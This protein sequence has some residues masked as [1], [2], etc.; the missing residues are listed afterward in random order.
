MFRAPGALAA[1]VSVALAGCVNVHAPALPS[2][3]VPAPPPGASA[4]PAAVARPVPPKLTLPVGFARAV[5]RGTRTTDGRPGAGYWTNRATY[6]LTASLDP[7][8]KRLNGTARIHY[9]HNGPVALRELHL[10][11]TQNVHKSG[12]MRGEAMEDTD[13]VEL[14]RVAVGGRTL[15]EGSGYAVDGTDLTI[16][17]AQPLATGQSVNLDLVWAFTIPQSGAGARM[18]YVPARGDLTSADAAMVFLAYWYPQ[19]AVYDDVRGWNTDPFRG[20]GEF[21]AGYGDYTMTLD[22]PAGWA[23]Q[24]TGTLANPAEVYTSETNARLARAAASDTPV[25]IAT[26]RETPTVAVP[27]GGRLRYRY[28]ASNVRDVAFFATRG[29]AW[30]AARTVVGDQ[31]GDGAPD[32]ALAQALYRTSAPRWADGKATRYTQ[33]ATRVIGETAGIVYP[34]PHMTVVEGD[35]LMGGGMEYP[36][37]S[38]IGSYTRST[39]ADLYAVVAHEIAHMW[40]PMIVS[41][42]ERRHGWMDEGMTM[43]EENQAEKSFAPGKGDYDREDAPSY[44]RLANAGGEGEMMRW[45]DFHY[46]SSASVVASYDKPV[47]LLVALRELLG[48]DVFTRAWQGFHR[49]WAYKH[50]TPYDFFNAFEREAGRDLD[51][52]WQPWYFTTGTL[53]H[54][55][56]SVTRSGARTTITVRDEGQNPMPV[57]LL[58]TYEGGRTERREIPVETWLSGADRA[59][60]TVD[61]AVTKVEIDPDRYFP[62]VDRADNVWPRG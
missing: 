20:S 9:T 23:V 62:D 54:A 42:D 4:P 47:T 8:A 56:E 6:D 44:I 31:N 48:A 58:V 53:D 61:G 37:L 27:A 14:S 18:G 5:E 38:L 41:T 16:R 25:T 19:M 21:Y 13:G 36:M 26:N 11:L 1:V 57:R 29:Y 40:V 46:T 50:P 39:D 51:W 32:A 60:I 12:A 52:F 3:V 15:G 22:V 28:T 45:S 49:D 2:I 43:Y 17:L 7:A 10:E 55:V 33:H 24:S 59:T 35:G 30:Q 34:W